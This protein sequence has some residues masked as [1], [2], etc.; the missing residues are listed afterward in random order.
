MIARKGSSRG[1]R[2]AVVV[3]HG[4][5]ATGGQN[6]DLGIGAQEIFPVQSERSRCV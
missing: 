5:V 6:C 3:C 1:R 4:G 2:E